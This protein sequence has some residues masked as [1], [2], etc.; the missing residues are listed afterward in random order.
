MNKDVNKLLL[1]HYKNLYG[2]NYLEH[3]GVK[4]QKW[5]VRRYQKKDGSL[6][7]LGK[8]KR[9]GMDTDDTSPISKPN[10]E[11]LSDISGKN[12]KDISVDDA[13]LFGEDVS[14]S[15]RAYDFNK[16]GLSSK[17]RDDVKKVAKDYKEQYDR[18]IKESEEEDLDFGMV[19]DTTIQL[20]SFRDKYV[21]PDP[22][23]YAKQ[24][25]EE[26]EALAI[27]YNYWK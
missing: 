18:W 5:G 21:K 23:A 15:I 26:S 4:G 7:A 22:E 8:A 10:N 17:N 14:W 25:M 20:K 1:S 3:H 19:S 2:D 24:I 11:R 13:R 27:K 12:A 9:K 16:G 6:T